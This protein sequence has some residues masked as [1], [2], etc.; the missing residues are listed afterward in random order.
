MRLRIVRFLAIFLLLLSSTAWANTTYVV[1]DG[2]ILG[3]I[4]AQHGCT[5]A[6][7]VRWNPN[8]DPDR[9][10]VGQR[11]V[12][13]STT[14]RSAAS[15]SSSRPNEYTVVAG[16]T[17]G[18]I[19]VKLGVS[20]NALVAANR[21]V[22]PDRIIIG[23]TLRV[24]TGSGSRATSAAVASGRV[25]VV[26]A[27]ETVSAIAASY[28]VSVA[29]LQS[30]NRGLNPDRISV[31]QQIH[32][33]SGRPVRELSYTVVQG[34]IMGRI[35][36]RHDVTVSELLSW[37]RGLDPNRIRIGQTIR[38][39]QEG[40]EEVSESHG[41][42]A[43]GRLVNGEQLPRHS[44]YTVRSSRRAWGTND[45]ISYLMAGYDHVKRVFPNI[46]RIAIHDLSTEKGGPLPPHRS[47]QSGRDADIGYYHTGCTATDCQYRAIRARELLPEYQWELF[48]FWIDQGTVEYLFVDYTLQEPLYEYAKSK[49]VS[50]R[51]LDRIFQYPR[52]RHARSGIIRHEPGH[53]THF[54]VR[55][56]CNPRDSRCR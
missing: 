29:D 34:D 37:N 11:I 41:S 42:A 32:V 56:A 18:G 45:T 31:G 9:I 17:M 35:A 13:R 30:W 27:G 2:D 14:G 6:D 39:F 38:I 5:V 48:K 24:P 54:H 55:F 7:I 46:P 1:K 19:A 43:D 10:R 20:Y 44:A 3:S 8:L 40:P 47:H 4:A 25:H 52:G 33:R 49:G 12:I 28:G 50:S 15:S 22:E 36:E 51:Q 26:S 21:G 23:Q 16:D 53:R